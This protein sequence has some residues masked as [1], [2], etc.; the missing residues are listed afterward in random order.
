MKLTQYAAIALE[1]QGSPETGLP[2]DWAPKGLKAVPAPHPRNW[3]DDPCGKCAIDDFCLTGLESRCLG[4]CR[5][6]LPVEGVY[7]VLDTEE[8]ALLR[9]QRSQT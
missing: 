1:L 3:R 7:Y 8:P 9:I 2:A 5:T 6:G 4:R